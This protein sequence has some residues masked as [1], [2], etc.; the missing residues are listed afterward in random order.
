MGTF[1]SEALKGSKLSAAWREYVR[2]GNGNSGTGTA[3]LVDPTSFVCGEEA[4]LAIAFALD[5]MI[6]RGGFIVFDLPQGWGGWENEEEE[7]FLKES[8]A[9]QA[10]L[11]GTE[12]A[13]EIITR[14]SR[15]SII[16]IRFIESQASSGSV[17]S[18][19]I[20]HVYPCDRPGRYRFH[21]FASNQELDPAPIVSPEVDVIVGPWDGFDLNYPS[22]VP[23]HGAVALT[24]R[25]R[26]GRQSS[27]FTVP[28]Y[29]G[30]VSVDSEGLNGS[31]SR[32][33]FTE[34]NQGFTRVSGFKLD[35]SEGRILVGCGGTEY[36][37]HPLIS[38]ELIDGMAVY[39]GDL[40]LHTALSDGMGTA[41]EA[42]RWAAD[43][44]G[45]DFSALNDHVESRLTYDRAWNEKSWK[46]LLE[47][48]GAFDKPGRFVTIPGVEVGGAINLYFRNTDY[49]FCPF[50]LYD[51]NPDAVREMLSAFAEDDSVLFGYH[52]L[53]AL[54]ECFLRFSPPDLVEIIQQKREPEIGIER[55]LPICD[56]A[57][58]FL[59]GS[60]SHHGLAASP[61]IGR[62]REEA[63]YGLTGVFADRLE[64]EHIFEALSLGRTFATSGQRSVVY[65]KINEIPMGGTLTFATP[66]EKLTV[67]LLIRACTVV[68]SVEILCNSRVI[69]TEYPGKEYVDTSFDMARPFLESCITG[70]NYFVYARIKEIT[71]KRAW[72]TP[73]LIQRCPGSPGT[74]SRFSD[75]YH[76]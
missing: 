22:S 70:R 56:R 18:V 51:R 54:E 39:F 43:S 63:Q 49:P 17:L 76:R 30:E 61:P 9:V 11:D 32:V 73:V 24:V 62:S 3:M 10:Y 35:G 13:V 31:R 2:R 64:R 25:A 72:T 58:S 60:D 26:S 44:A 38:T 28:R 34:K 16:Q 71:A 33:S 37:G 23:P 5:E 52:K 53:A 66:E 1:E 65:L 42:Y 36:R 48:A 75:Q 47:V 41:E 14:G 57:P 21:A 45:L 15:L 19:E 40:H 8:G 55:F 59:G 50:H 27:Y 7:I 4:N 20:P 6:P 12:V 67:S 74:L 29:V 68:D 69:H 46:N